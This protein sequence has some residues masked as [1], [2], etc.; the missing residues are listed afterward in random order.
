[1]SRDGEDNYSQGS[2]RYHKERVE[3]LI[4]KVLSGKLHIPFTKQP[5]LTYHNIF[6]ITDAQGV[7]EHHA[8]L[9]IHP[10]TAGMW[11]IK[12]LAGKRLCNKPI[13]ARQYFDRS[14]RDRSKIPEDDRRRPNT[15]RSGRE[16]IHLDVSAYDQFIQEHKG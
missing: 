1:M 16:E 12:H 13:F 14:N 11:L 6:I 8:L 9:V 2:P 7:Q 3:A 15:E 4:E 10:E 5:E